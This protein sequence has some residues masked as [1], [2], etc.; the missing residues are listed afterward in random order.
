MADTNEQLPGREF[1]L[2]WLVM[3]PVLFCVL[4]FAFL[5]NKVASRIRGGEPG[6][7]AGTITDTLCVDR[8]HDIS[9]SQCVRYCVKH[10]ANVKYA[11][12]DGSHVYILSD[13]QTPE[14][15][16]GQK[17]RVTGVLRESASLIEVQSIE[18]LN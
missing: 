5:M 12:Y 2:P 13:Q 18:P 10:G 9:D 14:Q 1:L 7:F 6:M 15:F 4:G 3:G 16:A 8:H 17:S 11:L